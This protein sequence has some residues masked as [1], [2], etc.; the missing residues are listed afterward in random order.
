MGTSG[1]PLFNGMV[2]GTSQGFLVVLDKA[3]NL[4][5]LS[6]SSLGG[7]NSPD[8]AVQEFLATSNTPCPQANTDP[9]FYC[10]EP[11]SMVYWNSQLYIWPLND[12]LLVFEFSNG[13]FV[14]HQ[15]AGT[16]VGYPG[17]V[18]A[19]SSSGTSNGI[20]WALTSVGSR[21]QNKPG[22]L[23]AIDATTLSTLWTSTD[24]MAFSTFAEATVANGRVYIPTAS[25]GLL[26]YSNH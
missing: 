11:H 23:T 13:L 21:T 6:Q 19:L 8:D 18:L 14:K 22:A 16:K 15:K 24:A 4:F 26:V 25:S 5:L 10:N 7:F 3:G 9:S 20:L 2:N 12:P 1:V 17:G